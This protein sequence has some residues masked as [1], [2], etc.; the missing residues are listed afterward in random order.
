MKTNRLVS[1]FNGLPVL[2]IIISVFFFS[3]SLAIILD[4]I[5]YIGLTFLVV[6]SIFLLVQEGFFAAFIRSS[7]RFFAAMSKYE[8]TIRDVEG[9]SDEPN[10]YVKRFPFVKM[11]FVM[12]AF[13]FLL[14]TV[15]SLLYFYFGR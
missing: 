3:S 7:K 9:R 6:G 12:G 8:Q 5:F 11:L 10:F 2:S 13:Y 1:I 4:I 15:A 14:S